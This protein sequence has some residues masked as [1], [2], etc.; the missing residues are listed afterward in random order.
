V[1]RGGDPERGQ[2]DGRDGELGLPGAEGGQTNALARAKKIFCTARPPSTPAN[3]APGIIATNISSVTTEPVP[4][5]R[6]PLS[7]TPAA[8]AA[9]T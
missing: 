1:E 9:S 4:A 3:V 8:Y 5:G 7:A 6:T 2:E